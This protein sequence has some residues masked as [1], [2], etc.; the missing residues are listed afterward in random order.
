MLCSNVCMLKTNLQLNSHN[1]KNPAV[2]GSGAYERRELMR[3]YSNFW[4]EVSSML[5]GKGQSP[6]IQ[7]SLSYN[8]HM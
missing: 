1:Q 2:R 3:V 4:A 5:E 6:A 8:S 7:L